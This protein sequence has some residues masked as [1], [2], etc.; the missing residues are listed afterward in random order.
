[1]NTPQF[2]SELKIQ[3]A[4]LHQP[5][6]A[7]EFFYRGIVAIGTGRYR[8]ELALPDPAKGETRP[9]CKLHRL[10]GPRPRAPFA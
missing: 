4:T 9:R 6:P 7:D 2:S 10:S 5:N 8:M 1:M 3:T